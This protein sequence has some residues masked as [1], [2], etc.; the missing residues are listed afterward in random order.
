M[1]VVYFVRHAKSSW[2]EPAL[3]DFDR[4]LNK[5]GLRDAPFMGKLMNAKESRPD[6]LISSPALR[7]KTT[8]Y[9]FAEALGIEKDK[10]Q[11][12]PAI[13]EAFT[14]ELLDIVQQLPDAC[15]TVMLFGHNPA[16]TSLANKFSSTPIANIPT[17]GIFKVEAT[18]AKWE[19]FKEA[20][21]R[22]TAFHYP[23]QYFS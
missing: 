11:L 17:C 1:K 12:N 13:Y 9:Y 8:A 10:V 23:K 20:N 14:G 18:V 22:L 16:L 6:A 4:P 7:A 5:R 21:G 3:K 2:A 15:D 19:A